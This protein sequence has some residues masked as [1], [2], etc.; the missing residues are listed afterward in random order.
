MPRGD[1][2]AGDLA[3][4]PAERNELVRERFEVVGIGD[5]GTLLQPV[6]VDDGRQVRQTAVGGCHE[7]LPVGAL[8]QERPQRLRVEVAADGQRRVERVRGVP[9]GQDQPVPLGIPGALEPAP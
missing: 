6:P 4:L 5:A 8:L 1:V 9:L 3:D 7:R 2:V